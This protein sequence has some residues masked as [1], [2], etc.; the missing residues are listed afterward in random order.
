MISFVSVSRA[1]LVSCPTVS[2]TTA[3]LTAEL[4][5]LTWFDGVNAKHDPADKT[6]NDIVDEGNFIFY[7]VV[8]SNLLLCVRK[9]PDFALVGNIIMRTARSFLFDLG[10]ALAVS[11]VRLF[12]T[13]DAV[14]D[15]VGK[16][17]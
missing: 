11:I 9:T 12:S 17:K 13:S 6:R 14:C 1:V 3:L 15:V 8:L 5:G 7:H 4:K 16:P 2:S 10:V